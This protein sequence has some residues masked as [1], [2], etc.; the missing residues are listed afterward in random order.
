MSKSKRIYRAVSIIIWVV[1]LI[2][3]FCLSHQDG[4][5]SSKTSGTLTLFLEMIF[6]T[7]ISESFLRTVA[8]FCEYAF[9][10]FVTVNCSY[11]VKGHLSPF[12]SIIFGALYAVFDESHQYLIP[13]R[14][15]QFSDF[16]VDFAGVIAGVLLFSVLYI[17][18]V[19]IRKRGRSKC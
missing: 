15:M 6:R 11:A 1:T 16:A 3:I 8:H 9:L 12:K 10:G 14:A 17:I 2:L 13:G 18:I 7:Q 19:K 5:E 4:E